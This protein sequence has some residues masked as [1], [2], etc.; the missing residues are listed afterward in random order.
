[1]KFYVANQMMLAIA[2]LLCAAFLVHATF[3]QSF[4]PW[5]EGRI[6]N[7]DFLDAKRVPTL[8]DSLCAALGARIY[9]IE[10]GKQTFKM[11]GALVK[12]LSDDERNVYFVLDDKKNANFENPNGGEQPATLIAYQSEWKEAPANRKVLPVRR[13][14]RDWRDAKLIGVQPLLVLWTPPPDFP[15]WTGPA[16]SAARSDGYISLT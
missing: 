3:A 1:M 5:Q 12:G 8:S 10:T 7:I 13:M 4:P 2:I 6:T 15:S 11:L 9:T 14:S 16:P